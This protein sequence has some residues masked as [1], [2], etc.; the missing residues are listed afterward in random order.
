MATPS[1]LGANLVGKKRRPLSKFYS[2]VVVTCLMHVSIPVHSATYVGIFQGLAGE[3][4]YQQQFDEQVA[5]IRQ[6][7]EKLLERDQSNE[8]RVYQADQ[9]TKENMLAWLE[10]LSQRVGGTDRVAL[11][12]I[13]HGTFDDK[14]YKFNLV[15]PDVS[16]SELKAVWDSL[17]AELKLIVNTSSSSGALLE[18]FEDDSDT[19]LVTATKSGRERNATRF[20]RFFIAALTD[21]SADLDKNQLISLDEAFQFSSRATEDYYTSEGLIATEHPVL[22]GAH[23]DLFEL[24]TL[25]G[26]TNKNVSPELLELHNRRDQVDLDIDRLRMRRIGMTEEEYQQE[27]RRLIVQLSLLQAEI[28]AQAG[29]N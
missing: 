26:T 22:Q 25:S 8:V 23:G 28:D 13:G 10:G 11:F 16:D 21:E 14:N 6:A 19:L 1:S 17:Q 9:A 18:Q 15:G 12:Y 5:E 20:G 29:Q 7:A 24:S 27:F 4:Y 3:D 2:A